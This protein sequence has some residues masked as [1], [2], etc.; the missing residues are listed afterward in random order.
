MSWRMN[1][2]I[3]FTR[4][5][6]IL[7]RREVKKLSTQSISFPRSSNRSQRCEPMNP[8][9]PVTSMRFIPNPPSTV[10]QDAPDGPHPVLPVDFLPLRVRST[11]VADSDFVDPAT[12][13]RHL[14]GH[15]W[16]KS[17]TVLLDPDLTDNF[18]TEDFIA[19]LHVRQIDI[20]KH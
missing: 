9:P 16:L 11:G 13:P 18:S 4:R 14:G 10:F 6:R 2:N 7:F 1:S 5:C 19:R 3:G 8:A 15:L 20:G 17:E 12:H